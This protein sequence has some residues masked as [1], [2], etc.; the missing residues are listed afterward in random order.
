VN[1]LRLSKYVYNN[2]LR[3]AIWYAVKL[4]VLALDSNGELTWNSR[5]QPTREVGILCCQAVAAFSVMIFYLFKHAGYR[6]CVQAAAGGA[7]CKHIWAHKACFKVA[8]TPTNLK[9]GPLANSPPLHFIAACSSSSS[10][11]PS[12]WC[13]A[14]PGIYVCPN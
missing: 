9:N 4:P 8:T 1:Y 2:L 7:K 12:L 3:T 13:C 14:D 6:L 10:I 5:T 11:A